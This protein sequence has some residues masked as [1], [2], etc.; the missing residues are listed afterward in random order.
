LKVIVVFE[1]ATSGTEVVVTAA[2][3]ELAVR[4]VK[5]REEIVKANRAETAHV[6]LNLCS[7]FKIPETGRLDFECTITVLRWGFPQFFPC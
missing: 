1:P 7:E 4:V 6:R 5:P 2:S 3:A